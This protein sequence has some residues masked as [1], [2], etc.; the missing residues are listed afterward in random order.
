MSPTR[1]SLRY[2]EPDADLSTLNRRAF[3]HRGSTSRQVQAVYVLDLV[4]ALL[5]VVAQLL[6]GREV[7]FTPPAWSRVLCFGSPWWCCASRCAR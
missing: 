6:D 3:L 1:V 5:A 2:G 4:V 7:A